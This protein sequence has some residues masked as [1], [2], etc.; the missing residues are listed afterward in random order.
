MERAKNVRP[1]PAAP[2]ILSDAYPLRSLYI[3]YY[4]GFVI[5]F[6]YACSQLAI[7]YL[8]ELVRAY[9]KLSSNLAASVLAFGGIGAWEKRCLLAPGN[10]A[11]RLDPVAHG[12]LYSR[13]VPR[14]P[15]IDGQMST[16]I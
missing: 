11:P 16:R 9:P 15:R 4:F 10:P 2:A 5:F 7:H 1:K 12:S 6:G 13:S 14:R 8:P 3:A